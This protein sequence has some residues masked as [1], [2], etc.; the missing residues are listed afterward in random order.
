MDTDDKFDNADNP[1][2]P[3]YPEHRWKWYRLLVKAEV[4]LSCVLLA[5]VFL[6]ILI[7]VFFRYVLNS[8]LNWSEELARF[9]FIWLIF[10]S[11]TFV[12]ARRRHI[13]VV[14]FS[15]ERIGTRALSYIEAAANFIALVCTGALFVSA[16]ALVRAS[17]Q[18]SGAVTNIPFSVVY[19]VCVVTFGLMA[20][21][22]VV[23]IWL[24]IKHPEQFEE[25]LDL[26]RVGV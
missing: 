10:C 18:L 8:P 2:S 11:A 15:A 21:H 17:T 6:L 26:S 20:L 24:A 19:G 4:I 1:A 3:F 7:Q 5:L 22:L 14:L 25:K 16:V 9:F 23:N 13:S 12:M